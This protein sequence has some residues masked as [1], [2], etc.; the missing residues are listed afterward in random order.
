MA[1]EDM[2]RRIEEDN[3]REIKKI[4]AQSLEEG[5]RLL[6]EAASEI[7]K[8][9]RR[10]RTETASEIENERKR[11]LSAERIALKNRLL[12]LKHEIINEVFEEAFKRI[13]NLNED[14]YLRLFEKLFLSCA[15]A[16]SGMIYVPDG[17]RDLISGE[18]ISR[19]NDKLRQSGMECD[20][21]LSDEDSGTDRGFILKTGRITIDSGFSAVF[22]NARQ[23]LEKTAGDILFKD[24]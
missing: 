3:R 24:G 22:M 14:E 11:R 13:R 6:K 8:M 7:D 23:E 12:E 2:L 1:I 19:M 4:E 17:D 5:G 15:E 10:K 16:G 18:F 21:S 20:Y 9:R